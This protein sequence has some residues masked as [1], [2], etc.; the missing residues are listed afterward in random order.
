MSV[1]FYACCNGHVHVRECMTL[2]NQ[3]GML[4]LPHLNLEIVL[5]ITADVIDQTC[6]Q[7]VLNVTPYMYLSPLY[8]IACNLHLRAGLE[9]VGT[10]SCVNTVHVHVTF[11]YI[12]SS[13]CA[14]TCI[15]FQTV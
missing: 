8:L 7:H 14:L 13:L 11:A 1:S 15:S 4:L 9:N 6:V 12:F 5:I 2:M 10:C 3:A